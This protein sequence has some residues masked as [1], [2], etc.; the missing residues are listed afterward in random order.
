M[1]P[2]FRVEQFLGVFAAYNMA[3]WPA[4]IV[5]Y[6]LG[7]IAVAAFGRGGFSRHG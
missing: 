5:A 7:L 2:P 6:E 3:I 1:T 4:Q